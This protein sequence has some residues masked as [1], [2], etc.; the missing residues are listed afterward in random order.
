[1]RNFS[2][3]RDWFGENFRERLPLLLFL[4]IFQTLY[5]LINR[6][7]ANRGGFVADIPAIDGKMPLIGVFVVPYIGGLVLMPLFPAYAAWKFPRHLFQEYALGF[8]TIMCVGYS[9]W[10]IFPAYVIKEPINGS[11]IFIDLVKKLHSGDDSYGTHNAI[12][13]SHVYYV[14]LAMCYYIRYNR[15]LFAPFATFA[16]V[17]AL[18]TMFTHQHYFLDVIAGFLT[19]WSVYEVTRRWLAPFARRAEEKHSAVSQPLL[20]FQQEKADR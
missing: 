7:N 14:T 20:S 8:F 12:P 11:G 3:K 16:V 1:M 18:S 13:S 2:L 19:T 5:F 17:N 6:F 15:K 9:I 4:L 10:I